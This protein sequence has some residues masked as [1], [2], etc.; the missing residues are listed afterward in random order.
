MSYIN[1]SSQD[2]A[3]INKR[4]TCAIVK[5]EGIEGLMLKK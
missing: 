4:D 1:T 5:V 3:V 2:Y